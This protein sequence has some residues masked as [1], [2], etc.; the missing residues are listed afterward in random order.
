MRYFW[1][2]L[3]LQFKVK[4]ITTSEFRCNF[5]FKLVALTWLTASAWCSHYISNNM[6][7]FLVF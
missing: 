3:T 1:P 2:T 6:C 5:F 7:F 4:L